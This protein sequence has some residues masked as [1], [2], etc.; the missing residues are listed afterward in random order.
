MTARQDVEEELAG[1]SGGGMEET[2]QVNQFLDKEHEK[3]QGV[4]DESIS[5]AAD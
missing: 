5:P 2:E 1:P 4:N 3:F